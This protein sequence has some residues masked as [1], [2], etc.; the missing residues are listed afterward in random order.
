MAVACDIDF[1]ALGGDRCRSTEEH[2]HLVRRSFGARRLLF[3]VADEM[4]HNVCH[5]QS[6][7]W[8]GWLVGIVMVMVMAGRVAHGHES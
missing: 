3:R 5:T 6:P 1:V 2:G 7:C 4:I 8:L